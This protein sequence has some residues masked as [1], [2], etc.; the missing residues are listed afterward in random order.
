MCLISNLTTA[1]AAFWLSEEPRNLFRYLRV[2][3]ANRLW[4]GIFAATF[5]AEV[6]TAN[7]N[8]GFETQ[9]KT[10]KILYA[11]LFIS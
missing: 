6:S 3:D 8:L 9:T 2:S 5:L 11:V 10:F 7:L 4:I 1:L